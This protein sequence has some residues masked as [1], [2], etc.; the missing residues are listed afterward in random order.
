MAKL[1]I[2]LDRRHQIFGKLAYMFQTSALVAAEGY[3]AKVCVHFTKQKGPRFSVQRAD[4]GTDQ[5]PF[6]FGVLEAPGKTFVAHGSEVAIPE[7]SLV[8]VHGSEA[9]VPEFSL[10]LA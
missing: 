10:V 7:F 3:G 2:V 8:L 5:L 9:E 1:F 4:L 6:L